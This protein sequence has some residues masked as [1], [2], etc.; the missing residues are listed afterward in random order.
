MSQALA[1][2]A[3]FV[4]APNAPPANSDLSGAQAC[5]CSRSGVAITGPLHAYAEWMLMVA[6][7]GY[8]P[9]PGPAAPG[10]PAG[11]CAIVST[12]RASCCSAKSSAASVIAIGWCREGALSPRGSSPAE[13]SDRMRRSESDRRRWLRRTASH[14]STRESLAAGGRGPIVRSNYI[15]LHALLYQVAQVLRQRGATPA[16]ALAKADSAATARSRGISSRRLSGPRTARAVHPRRH[17]AGQWVTKDSVSAA[18]QQRS[19]SVARDAERRA[20]APLHVRG[21]RMPRARGG[22]SSC[23]LRSSA[24]A[25]S[26]SS[27]RPRCAT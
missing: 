9:H 26:V 4:G 22:A 15:D 24:P 1:R 25:P 3:V 18:Q 20:T 5:P 23:R 13:A 11:Q 2:P 21:S 19:S 17:R 7:I 16:R 8:A 12:T 27:S 14:P 10:A 6:G